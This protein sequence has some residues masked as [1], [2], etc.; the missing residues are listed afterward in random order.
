MKAA[1]AGFWLFVAPF[2]FFFL[3][4]AIKS[5]RYKKL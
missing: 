5:A 1:E 2:S 3:S 4:F